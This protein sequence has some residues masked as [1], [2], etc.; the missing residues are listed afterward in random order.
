MENLHRAIDAFHGKKI[1]D[2]NQDELNTF[3][4][5]IAERGA[6]NAL[7]QVGLGDADAGPDIRDLRD[8][9]KGY[10]FAKKTI[11]S[12]TLIQFG[13][14]VGIVLTLWL[15]GIVFRGTEEAKVIAKFLS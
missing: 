2:L 13:K 5:A 6:Y 10:R 1:C 7:Q 14:I 4:S 11:W 9:M 12:A 15:L 8:L 3:L